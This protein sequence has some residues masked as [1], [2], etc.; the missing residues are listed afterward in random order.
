MSFPAVIDTKTDTH[1][2]WVEKSSVTISLMELSATDPKFGL[3][4]SAKWSGV[5]SGS[6]SGGPYPISGNGSTVVNQNPQV[7][8][9]VSDYT[10]TGSSISLH[11]SVTV[12]AGGAIGIKTVFDDSLS[13]KYPQTGFSGMVA[14]MQADAAETATS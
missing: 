7:T 3:S 10:D 5:K 4:Y 2:W 13:G 12:D 6:T 8:L 14:S 1:N 9:V 11:V